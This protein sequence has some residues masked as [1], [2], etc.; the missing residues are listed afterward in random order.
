[1]VFKLD[2]DVYFKLAPG[3]E[4]TDRKTGLPL[5]MKLKRSLYDLAQL[6]A[7]RWDAAWHRLHAYVV[8]PLHLHA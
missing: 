6:P 3:Q 4:A 8:R 2:S 5:V 1:M 7:R